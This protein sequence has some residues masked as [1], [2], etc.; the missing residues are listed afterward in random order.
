MWTREQRSAYQREWRQ[1]NVAKAREAEA[2]WRASNPHKVAAK[3]NRRTRRRR[4]QAW[5]G[6]VKAVSYGHGGVKVNCGR[7]VLV[8]GEALRSRPGVW[9]FRFD[10]PVTGEPQSV[11]V[12][13]ADREAAKRQALGIA[14][15]V[16]NPVQVADRRTW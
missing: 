14:A 5:A 3:E 10:D 13:A 2:R 15:V 9:R 8:W 1:R 4:Q 7:E 6:R 12:G 11:A 16:F